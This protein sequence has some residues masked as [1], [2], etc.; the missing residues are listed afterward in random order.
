[1]SMKV[2]SKSIASM[3]SHLDIH[4]VWPANS[5]E[6]AGALIQSGY[7]EANRL[8]GIISAWQEGTEVYEVNQNA[9]I[10]PVQVG[11]ELFYLLKRSLKISDLTEGLFDVTFASIDKV[12][13]FDRPMHALPSP[14]AVAASVRN[15]D[16]RHI[17]L[18]E[19]EKTVYIA[20][21]GTKIEL[22][23]I[24]KGFIAQKIRN[25]LVSLGV[26]GGL[27]NAGGDLI[28]W[29]KN[30]HGGKWKVGIADP[31]KKEK[32]IAFLPLE[33]QAVATSGGYERFAV[34]DGQ[35][36]AHIIH[37]HTGYPVSGISSVTVISPDA[38][39]CDAIATSVILKG[40]K[41]GLDFVNRFS[42]IQ[43]FIIDENNTRHYSENLQQIHYALSE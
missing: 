19:N 2:Y 42:D 36:Y 28:T 27:V 6:E 37:P 32:H 16:Y 18:D 11:D 23:A 4:I 13:Y 1:M 26:T 24:G 15:I 41:D 38:E 34:I 5:A 3:T 20:N 22:G 43:C 39:L 17:F 9:G 8:I 10:R 33:N 12:W 21:A 35:R 40:V 30:E 29:G 7:D 31:E 25:R 14:E